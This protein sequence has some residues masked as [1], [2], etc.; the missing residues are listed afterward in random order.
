MA[1]TSGTVI[2]AGVASPTSGLRVKFRDDCGWDYYYGHL[3]TIAVS[4]G[5]HVEAGQLIG[6][7]GNTGK[8]KD[9]TPYSVHLHFNVSQNGDY[10]NDI[11]PFDL[12]KMTS[13]T[14][15]G[16]DVPPAPEPEP[17]PQPQPGDCASVLAPD[18]ALWANESIS[19]CNGLFT[20]VMQ[21]DGNVVLYDNRN[22]VALWHSQTHGTAGEVVVMQGDG[23]FVLYDA[24]LKA[25]WHTGTHGRP[26]S[27]LRVEEDGNV[28]IWDGWTEIWRAR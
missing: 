17:Q 1:V 25:L 26:G 10:N 4:Q 7:M 9:G 11:N 12:L 15:C 14:A 19:S 23:N 28:K 5:Q 18:Q 20:L 8:H 21:G 22:G 24:S 6:T 13:P 27:M 2:H 3:D 16:G